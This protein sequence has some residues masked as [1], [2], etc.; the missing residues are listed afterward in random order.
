MIYNLDF[1]DKATADIAWLKKSGN[2]ALLKKLLT[3]LG[4]LSEHPFSGTGK[5]ELLKHSFS[6]VWSRRIN[7]EHRLVYE[8]VDEIV[9]VLSVRGHYE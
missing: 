1:T 8:V 3:L 6:G 4:E 7:R 5:P 2:R 9:F